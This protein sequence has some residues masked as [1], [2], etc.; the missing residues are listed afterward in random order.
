[1]HQVHVK[2]SILNNDKSTIML[3]SSGR[4]DRGGSAHGSIIMLTFHTSEQPLLKL[5]PGQW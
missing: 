5:N 3:L 4:R 2:K 1:M